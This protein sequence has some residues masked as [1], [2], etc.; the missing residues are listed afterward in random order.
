VRTVEEI[1]K[2]NN[3]EKVFIGI[4][5]LM[6]LAAILFSYY[7]GEMKNLDKGG[8]KKCDCTVYVPTNGSIIFSE[9]ENDLV[10]T[11]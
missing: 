10:L 3:R 7:S 9:C 11:D 1:I 5:W 8:D 6:A 2:A 4:V